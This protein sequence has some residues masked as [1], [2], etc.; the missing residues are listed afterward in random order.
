MALEYPA[1]SISG[2]RTVTVKFVYPIG[3]SSPIP[4]IVQVTGTFNDWQRT[5]PLTRNLETSQ[6]EGDIVISLDKIINKNSTAPNIKVLYKFVLDDSNWVTDPKQETDRDYAGNLNNV[7]YINTVISDQDDQQHTRDGSAAAAAAAAVGEDEED[8]E[9][10]EE[11]RLKREAEDDAT[12]R[13]LGGGMWG[14]PFFS[15]NDPPNLP[16]HFVNNPDQDLT[17]V[18][19]V[20]EPSIETASVAAPI[21]EQPQV[22]VEAE[23]TEEVKTEQ[24]EVK[25][26]QE[27]VKAEQ[28]EV[29]AG[30]EDNQVKERY[31]GEDEDDRII[32]E[33]GGTMWG[34]PYFQVNDP[35]QLPEHFTEALGASNPEDDN[36]DAEVSV[37]DKDATT[38][39][40]E[41]LYKG[42]VLRD[43]INVSM[44]G[45]LL[46][47]VVETTEDTAIV[48]PDGTLLEESITTNVQETLSGQVEESVTEVVETVEDIE[49]A[50]PTT[51]AVATT[52]ENSTPEVT[53]TE[54]ESTTAI[55][56]EDGAETLVVEDTLTFSENAGIDSAPTAVVIEEPAVAQQEEASAAVETELAVVEDTIKYTDGP[57]VNSNNLHK[58]TTAIKPVLRGESLIVE[59]SPEVNLI[60]SIP[61]PFMATAG[62]KLPLIDIISLY[63]QH[64]DSSKSKIA[65]NDGGCDS[66]SVLLLQGQPPI[67]SSSPPSPAPSPLPFAGDEKRPISQRLSIAT[68]ESSDT[69]FTPTSAASTVSTAISQPNETPEKKKSLW[70][71]IKKVLK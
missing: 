21:E 13:E 32:R 58:L 71:K 68:I 41:N 48:A 66:D 26:E 11:E 4:E 42:E 30:Q 22:E 49:P 55:Q 63:T 20:E 8:E 17:D 57:E 28:E 40:P 18:T 65:I 16:E 54:T 33:L 27:E 61:E 37:V 9:E 3:A 25:A 36:T 56:G 12:I 67:L 69:A 24:E 29:K 7:I 45:T 70:K 51:V 50:T 31:E 2:R 44:E 39:L 53:M 35:A 62:Y 43:E 19:P 5:D 1:S 38:P 15:V 59:Q 52:A 6:F 60:I 23:T 47:T 34:T 14:T 46:E 64:N 10:D